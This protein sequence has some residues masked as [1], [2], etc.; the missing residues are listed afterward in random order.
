MGLQF[1]LKAILSW[2]KRINVDLP[3]FTPRWTLTTFFMTILWLSNLELERASRKGGHCRIRHADK[4][5]I[6][7]GNSDWVRLSTRVFLVFLSH[8]FVLRSQ[9]TMNLYGCLIVTWRKFNKLPKDENS[10]KGDGWT[11]T[12]SCD[13]K[14]WL[15]ACHSHVKARNKL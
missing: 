5:L 11:L 13:G 9:L 7:R 3:Y 2:D 8:S 4:Q 10:A 12:K 15:T 6:W 1:Y 14:K